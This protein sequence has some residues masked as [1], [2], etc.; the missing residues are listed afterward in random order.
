MPMSWPV[1]LIALTF[2]QGVAGS[3]PAAL[4]KEIKDLARNISQ[5][6]QSKS[7]GAACFLP[8]AVARLEPVDCR[9]WRIC[10]P[11]QSIPP[12]AP[13]GDYSRNSN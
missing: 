1:A 6:I 4:T 8:L 5:S 10:L 13:A 2:N 3:I 7:L 9:A 12:L 11:T